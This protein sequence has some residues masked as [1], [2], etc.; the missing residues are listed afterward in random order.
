[1]I[2]LIFLIFGIWLLLLIDIILLKKL[3]KIDSEMD[4]FDFVMRPPQWKR[5]LGLIWIAIGVFVIIIAV[6]DSLLE[7]YI[8]LILLGLTALGVKPFLTKIVV[9]GNVIIIHRFFRKVQ[10]TFHRISK[11][12]MEASVKCYNNP[13]NQY[14]EVKCYSKSKKKS[15]STKKLNFTSD[16]YGFHLMMQRLFDLGILPWL[17]TSRNKKDRKKMTLL[18]NFLIEH[19]LTGWYSFN[20]KEAV[21]FGFRLHDYDLT[22]EG[23]YL[24]TS[25]AVD[26]WIDFVYQ[27]GDV[28]DF[29]LLKDAMIE[30]EEDK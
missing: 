1:M 15:K 11:V 28:S 4:E 22:K 9:Q 23:Q 13:M 20:K 21:K 30:Y 7:I 27:G 16:W 2:D 12:K 3:H 24:F 25:G 5:M 10:V 18:M 26:K 17:E 29:S 6:R 14:V 19:D 8:G